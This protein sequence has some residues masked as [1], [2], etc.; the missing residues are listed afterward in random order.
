MSESLSEKKEV[1]ASMS[2]HVF[3]VSAAM[4]GVCLTVV[5]LIQLNNGQAKNTIA[6]EL[7]ALDSILFLLACFVSFLALKTR[8]KP[9]V[10]RALE[11]ISDGFFLIALSTVVVTCSLVVYSLI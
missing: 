5:Q 2:V 6:D 4:V 11:N 3:S 7:L 1:E 8:K 10:R 9:R